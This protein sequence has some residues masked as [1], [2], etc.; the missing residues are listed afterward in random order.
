M[1]AAAHISPTLPTDPIELVKAAYRAYVAKDR[2]TIEVIMAPD[3]VFTS[4][5]DNGIDRET[6]FNR[7]WPFSA[8]VQSFDFIFAVQDGERVFLTYESTHTGSK[9]FRNT[10]IFTVKNNQVTAVEVY[11]GWDV[12]HKAKPGEFLNVSDT[13]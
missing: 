2:A 8:Q 10:E 13:Q 1:T 9:K 12:P 7:C 4:M 5:Y 11:F 3:L 6:Y